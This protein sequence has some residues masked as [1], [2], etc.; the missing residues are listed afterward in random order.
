MDKYNEL[1][2]VCGA[3][4]HLKAYL[5]SHPSVTAENKLIPEPPTV[6]RERRCADKQLRMLHLICFCCFCLFGASDHPHSWGLYMH[7]V[8]KLMSSFVFFHSPFLTDG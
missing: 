6:Y 2:G 1:C 7:P 3:A 8:S 5:Q 4:V